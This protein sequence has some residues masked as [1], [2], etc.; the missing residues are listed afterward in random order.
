MECK[1]RL[2]SGYTVDIGP[3]PG[4]KF[5]EWDPDGFKKNVIGHWMKFLAETAEC[6][7]YRLVKV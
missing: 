7:Y 3:S 1:C 2:H 5:H 4:Y 6:Q